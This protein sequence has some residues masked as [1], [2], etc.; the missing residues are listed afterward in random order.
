MTP[1]NQGTIWIADEACLMWLG[2]WPYFLLCVT[3]DLMCSWPVAGKKL[4]EAEEDLKAATSALKEAEVS[5][6][7]DNFAMWTVT[8]WTHMSSGLG[9]A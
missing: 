8:A 5:D 1:I 3:P 7:A 4:E 6:P 2:V 9:C